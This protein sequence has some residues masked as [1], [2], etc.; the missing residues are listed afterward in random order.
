M[1]Y[2]NSKNH[3]RR[4]IYKART[5]RYLTARS[6]QCA[7]RRIFGGVN[8]SQGSVGRRRAAVGHVDEQEQGLLWTVGRRGGG[9]GGGFREIRQHRRTGQM[10]S[11]P[12]VV[13]RQGGGAVT[14]RRP[15]STHRRSRGRQGG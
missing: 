6:E 4:Y 14:A 8:A 10:V 2:Q 5:A 9:L 13:R 7:R 3:C 15:A 11:A 1:C 12:K